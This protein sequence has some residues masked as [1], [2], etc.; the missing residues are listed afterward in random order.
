VRA[1][2]TSDIYTLVTSIAGII[3]IF[4][5][6]ILLNYSRRSRTGPSCHAHFMTATRIVNVLVLGGVMT[7]SVFTDRN[8]Y[9]SL[10]DFMY[11]ILVVNCGAFFIWHFFA[12]TDVS[13][14]THTLV[15]VCR[16]GRISP[17]DLLTKYNKDVIVRAR[18]PRLIAINQLECS[19]GVLRV[20]GSTVLRNAKMFETLRGILG[21]PTRPTSTVI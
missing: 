15:L 5:F 12:L 9:S 7:G 2:F 1:Q 13:M 18:I 4:V 3:L 10:I 19:R 8:V 21:I 16:A 11:V 6:T 17:Q 20:V 14:H